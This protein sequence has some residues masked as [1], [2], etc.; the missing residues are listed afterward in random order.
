MEAAVDAGTL[1]RIADQIVVVLTAALG[2]PASPI[3]RLPIVAPSEAAVLD[4]VNRTDMAFDRDATIDRLIVAQAART[5]DAPAVSANGVT[6]PIARLAR[7]RRQPWPLASNRPASARGDRVGIA[8]ERGDR[9]ADRRARDTARG[10]AY[11][12]LDPAYPAERLRHMIADS[13]LRTLVVDRAAS[14]STRSTAT[15]PRA[16]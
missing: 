8:V 2:A 15:L 3:A 14:R 1:E 6:S 7:P 12:P 4:A 5:P 13:G 10:A 16:T 9:D 11:V